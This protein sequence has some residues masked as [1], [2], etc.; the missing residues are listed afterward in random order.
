MPPLAK[1]ARVSRFPLQP[2]QALHHGP[3]SIGVSDSLPA[4]GNATQL[5]QEPCWSHEDAELP[6]GPATYQDIAAG[7]W[8]KHMF[9]QASV[10]HADFLDTFAKNMEDGVVLT[11]SYSGIGSDAIAMDM[12]LQSATGSGL[13]MDF[14]AGVRVHCVCEINEECQSVLM[15]HAGPLAAKHIFS[16][17]CALVPADDMED[18]R[19]RLLSHRAAVDRQVVDAN[20]SSLADVRKRALKAEGDAFLAYAR[21]LMSRWKFSRK[22]KAMC[23]RC[24]RLCRRWPVAGSR[25]HVEVAGTVCV[26]HSTMGKGWGW[27]DNSVLPR[28]AWSA[29]VRQ[30]QP[31]LVVHE[32]VPQFDRSVLAMLLGPEYKVSSLVYSPVD[33]GIPSERVRRYSVADHISLAAHAPYDLNLFSKLAF[34]RLVVDA[35]I[36]FLMPAADLQAAKGGAMQRGIMGTESE[37]V[38]SS[39]SVS[40]IAALPWRVAGTPSQLDR[41][42]CHSIQVNADF[43]GRGRACYMAQLTQ[44]AD[45][46]PT[47]TSLVPALLRKSVIWRIVHKDVKSVEL[48]NENYHLEFDRPLQPL[49]HLAVQ[50]VPVASLLPVAHPSIDSSPVA[51]LFC[52][53]DYSA[54]SLRSFAGNS[55]HVAAIGS[56][57]AFR[58]FTA[59]R[60]ASEDAV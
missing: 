33:C 24:S 47:M 19:H 8:S 27:L 59:S 37:S 11:S 6:D 15:H 36:Y 22:D 26:G 4:V 2:S 43:L 56:V 42:L 60:H 53:G 12:I 40:D 10:H 32:C 7:A 16:D 20:K 58:L 1:R 18:L 50:G 28:L 49:E 34:R 51:K 14:L 57:L 31:H 35:N 54:V 30:I 25:L 41:L 52:R 55:M 21:R 38:K 48:G 23:K 29:M 5:P 3:R 39:Q 45:F 17:V 13:P 46:Q 9:S 44:N